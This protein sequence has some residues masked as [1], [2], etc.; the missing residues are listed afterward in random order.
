MRIY[1]PRLG[2][3]LSV[4]PLS[5]EYPWYTP[6]QFAGN[7]PIRCVDL[8]G[9]EPKSVVEQWN[10]YLEGKQR[11]KV[12]GYDIFISRQSASPDLD[13]FYF[14]NNKLNNGKG[15][16]EQF[17]PKNQEQLDKEK[18]AGIN[19]AIDDLELTLIVAANAPIAAAAAVEAAGWAATVRAAHFI[20]EEV[21]EEAFEQITGIPMITGV[22][23]LVQQGI[24]T[25]GKTVLGSFPDYIE[26]AKKMNASYFDIGEKW[27]LLNDA[28]RWAANKYFLDKVAKN[29]DDII[30]STAKGKIKK[31]TSLWKEVQYL[32][33][34]KGY[35]WKDDTTLILKK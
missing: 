17:F 29:G 22:F 26:M 34:E 9:L 2:R 23:D 15:G 10:G 24:K 11:L 18:V 14:F 1:D 31:G 30:L 19:K 25:T 4:D 6:Y 33:K 7:T 28:Q 8:D 12:D 3:F 27:K 20:A 16:W 35:I 5:P 13:R 21:A 32:T